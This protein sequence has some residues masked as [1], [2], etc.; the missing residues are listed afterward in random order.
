M[1]NVEV[2]ELLWEWFRILNGF[3]YS[4]KICDAFTKDRLL[5]ELE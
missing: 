2:I 3:L 4:L 5:I 1:I